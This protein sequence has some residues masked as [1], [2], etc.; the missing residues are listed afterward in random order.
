MGV[1]GDAFHQN[2]LGGDI[3]RK[4]IEFSRRNAITLLEVFRKNRVK[5]FQLILAESRPI[6]FDG[7][8]GI[9]C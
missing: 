6:R 4:Y 1:F 3:E 8:S 5:G 9:I 2:F 7:R